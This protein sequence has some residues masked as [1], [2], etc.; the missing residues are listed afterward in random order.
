MREDL[1]EVREHVMAVSGRMAFQ[2]RTR[3][4]EKQV[5]RPWGRGVPS[6]LRKDKEQGREQQ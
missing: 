1:K 5:Q 4:K 2:A 3:T 6:C